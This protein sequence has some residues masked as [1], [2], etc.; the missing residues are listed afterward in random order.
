MRERDRA[1]AGD[2]PD[3]REAVSARADDPARVA[4]EVDGEDGRGGI[5]AQDGLDW[6]CSYPAAMRPFAHAFGAPDYAE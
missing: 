1:A 6:S 4:I 3:P 5:R 2:V